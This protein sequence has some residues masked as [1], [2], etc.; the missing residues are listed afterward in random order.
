MPA[1]HSS[2]CYAGPS[3][4]QNKGTHVSN[5]VDKQT[6]HTK[7]TPPQTHTT[8]HDTHPT[9]RRTRVA[10]PLP[11]RQ[12]RVPMHTIVPHSKQSADINGTSLHYTDSEYQHADLRSPKRAWHS[13]EFPPHVDVRTT[14][15]FL[16][17]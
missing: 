1:P 2:A 6:R 13:G 7:R 11:R 17:M 3:A 14:G 4:A 15:H 9:I 16:S 12:H 10:S 8:T 5:V